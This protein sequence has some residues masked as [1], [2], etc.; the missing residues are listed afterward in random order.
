MEQCSQLGFRGLLTKPFPLR[1]LAEIISKAL[2]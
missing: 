2:I 1:M